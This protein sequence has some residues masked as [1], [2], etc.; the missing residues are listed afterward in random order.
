MGTFLLIGAVFGGLAALM[1]F[2]ITYEEHS[3]HRLSRPMLL[4]LALETALAA[5]LFFLA[6][7]L[8][9]GWYFTAVAGR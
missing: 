1:A 5:L 9:V 4:R 2:L 8:A 6:L 7:A 3:R